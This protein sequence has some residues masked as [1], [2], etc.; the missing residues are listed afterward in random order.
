[1][2]RLLM[3]GISHHAAP[4]EVRERL[5][6][7][8]AA[9]RIVAPATF[10]TVL[11]STCNRV[12]VYAWVEDHPAR[13]IRTLERCLARAAAIEVSTTPDRVLVS[14]TGVIGVP[15]PIET[16]SRPQAYRERLPDLH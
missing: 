10:S 1:M 13:A 3:V 11:L 14:S 9:W 8:D 4:L 16:T 2:A 6:V 5:A 15:L 12:E 7:D